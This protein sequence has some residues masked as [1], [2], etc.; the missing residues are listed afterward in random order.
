[1][2]IDQESAEKLIVELKGLH[3][4]V[5]DASVKT[6]HPYKGMFFVLAAGFAKVIEILER[7]YNAE[8]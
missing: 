4:V 8:Q 6:P 1:M 3:N 2:Y 7:A 5:Q